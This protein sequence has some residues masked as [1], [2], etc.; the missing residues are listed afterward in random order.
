[1]KRERAKE[2]LPI[3][4]AYAEGKQIQFL[5]RQQQ[6]DGEWID[7]WY[8]LAEGEEPE[9]VEQTKYRIKPEGSNKKF[10][11]ELTNLLNRYGYDTACD[12]P[13]YILADYIGKCLENYYAVIQSNIAWHTGWK[14]LGEE[15]DK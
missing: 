4:Q 11:E 14:R 8:D 6:E 3:I 12:T 9:F 13:D 5:S 1:M 7:I 2:L 10:K 15:A